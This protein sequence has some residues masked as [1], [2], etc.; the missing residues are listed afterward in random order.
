MNESDEEVA[1]IAARIVKQIRGEDRLEALAGLAELLD[2][3][4]GHQIALAGSL[5]RVEQ[6]L[7]QQSR[8]L[9]QSVAYAQLMT[10]RLKSNLDIFNV[11]VCKAINDLH[12]RED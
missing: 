10:E 1:E 6:D 8:K 5:K 12:G 11:A 2:M 4:L 3:C 7:G 9:L